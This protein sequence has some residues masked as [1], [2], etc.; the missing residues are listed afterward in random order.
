MNRIILS[1]AI[2]FFIIFP[3]SGSAQEKI[4]NEVMCLIDSLLSN[5]SIVEPTYGIVVKLDSN[6]CVKVQLSS[7]FDGILIDNNKL[8]FRYVTDSVECDGDLA[9]YIVMEKDEFD[10][11]GGPYINVFLRYRTFF[12]S[13]YFNKCSYPEDFLFNIIV[14]IKTNRISYYRIHVMEE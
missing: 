6:K 12:S 9:I 5:E 8:A 2:L 1:F 7:D 4:L 11:Y 10:I 3:S 13:Q 14:F